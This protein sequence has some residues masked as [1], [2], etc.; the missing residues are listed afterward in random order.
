MHVALS[1][2]DK[3]TALI[4]TTNEPPTG[5]SGKMSSKL[6]DNFFHFT[7]TYRFDSDIYF[8]YGLVAPKDKGKRYTSWG[9]SELIRDRRQ[10]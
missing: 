5:Q 4:Y 3:R 8:P 6:F 7:M 1:G 10:K 2:R 9:P